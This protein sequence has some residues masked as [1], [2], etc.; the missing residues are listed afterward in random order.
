MLEI[1]KERIKKFFLYMKKKKTPVQMRQPF[2]FVSWVKGVYSPH[3]CIDC[4][5]KKNLQKY[6]LTK[7]SRFS[8][9]MQK[10]Y[11]FIYSDIKVAIQSHPLNYR[12]RILIAEQHGI[13]FMSSL[14]CK[15]ILY[16]VFSL[17]YG[18]TERG[19]TAI[20]IIIQILTI[21]IIKM[22]TH[23]KNI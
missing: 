12:G 22:P 16:I 3:I 20:Y 1:F 17:K 4:K 10:H 19:T 11:D 15:Q 9:D 23:I 8:F 7:C 2:A 6:Y 5:P 18:F 14:F 21:T 13:P